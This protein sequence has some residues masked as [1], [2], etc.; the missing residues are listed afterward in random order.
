MTNR[1]KRRYEPD[2]VH[3]VPVLKHGDT[4]ADIQGAREPFLFQHEGRF[5][6][7]Y[8]GNGTRDWGCT[9]AVS[10]DLYHWDKKGRMLQA[11]E[12]GDT[13]HGGACYGPTFLFDGK[14]YMYYVSV[15]NTSGAPWFV[16]A[17]PYRTGLATADR[18]D[19]P[20]TKAT[21]NL[22]TLGAPGSWNEGCICAPYLVREGET[23]YAF[24]SGSNM[25][26]NFKRTIGLL[27]ASSPEGPWTDSEGPILPL[28]ENLENPSLYY[29][30]ACGLW[31]M[32]VNHVGNNEEGVEFT[33][34]VWVYW[35]ESLTEWNAENKAVV[36]DAANIPWVKQVVGLP[37]CLVDGDKLWI[38]F[39]ASDGTIHENLH[40]H[41]NRDIG[42]SYFDL[43]LRSPNDKQYLG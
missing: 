31:F 43:P 19:G 42:L 14:W 18:P 37:A 41:S 17:L 27:T 1:L 20:W 39:D 33:D 8:D 26:P 36:L 6:L 5:Y 40:G 35:S 2:Y 10:D 16:P 7:H 23:F 25:G 9:L 34:A 4:D 12:E 29:E 15:A 32:F 3:E 13:D 11:G 38:A 28:D 30:P 21:T 24:Y 22:F